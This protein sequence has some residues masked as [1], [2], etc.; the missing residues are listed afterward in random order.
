V[1]V[2][3]VTKLFPNALEPAFSPFNRH[4]FAAL[5]KLCHVEVLALLPWFPGARLLGRFSRAG[6]TTRV[7]ARE[8]I[9]D[10]PV[11]HPRV[12]Y[13]PRIGHALSGPLYAASLLPRVL[14]R[15]KQ[16]DVVLGSFA[17]PDG[18]AAVVLG[19]AMNIPTVIK[20]HGTDINVLATVPSIRRN[21]RWALSRASAVVATS[22]P[23]AEA[24]VNAGAVPS[25]TTVVMN[26][27]DTAAFR[28]R[29]RGECRRR[30]GYDDDT[31]WILYV[32]NLKRPKGILDLLEAFSIV[33]AHR[34]DVRLVLVGDGEQ[35]RECRA[36]VRARNLPVVFIGA[37]PHEQIPEWMGACDVLA[38]PSWA[39][40]TPNVVLEAIA[41]DRRVVASNVG[42]I[43]AIVTSPDCGELVAPRDPSGLAGALA[44]A[45]DAPYV[46]GRVSSCAAFS[47][48]GESAGRL[49]AVLT[50]AVQER[51]G[52]ER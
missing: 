26:G 22:K 39:E 21:L 48:W 8:T 27:I 25:R 37:L 44:R 40:G 2:L 3:V 15:R 45:L 52:D 29:D 41:S 47:G 46:A 16:F 49:H 12:L 43:P 17:Y 50:R 20:V 30:L 19:R 1:R 24:A 33:A 51:G 28:P 9:D 32:G 35:E 10:L 23:L 38:L 18:F 13:V 31:K 11:S 14:P 4:Q 42:G 34:S 7:P 5:G 36:L 6:N